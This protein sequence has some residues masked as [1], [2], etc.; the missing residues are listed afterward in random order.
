[1]MVL[2]H[3]DP[4]IGVSQTHSKGYG[5]NIGVGGVVHHQI[6][7]MSPLFDIAEMDKITGILSDLDQWQALPLKLMK[8]NPNTCGDTGWALLRTE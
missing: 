7:S 2:A 1:M 5:S 8:P 6:T 3:L 4:N